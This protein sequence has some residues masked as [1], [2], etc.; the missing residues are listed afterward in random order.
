M[1]LPISGRPRLG[2]EEELLRRLRRGEPVA[3]ENPRSDALL[4]PAVNVAV[5]YC[6]S[7]GTLRRLPAD[8]LLFVH[9]RGDVR[10]LEGG[11]LAC[12]LADRTTGETASRRRKEDP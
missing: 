8:E 12:G 4:A 6:T 1:R 3:F 10:V 9:A 5:A 7:P 2:E 11:T